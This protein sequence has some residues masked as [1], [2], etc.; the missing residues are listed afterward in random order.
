[1]SGAVAGQAAAAASIEPRPVS[2]E[3]GVAACFPMMRQLRPHLA[4]AAEFVER[5]RRQ[6]E[7]GY[8]LLALWKD[9][10]PV[11]LA[12][13]RVQENLVHGRFLYV[14]DLVTDEAERGSGFGERV[15][16]YL[17]AEAR[18]LDCRKLVLD[19]ALD[20]VRAHRFYYRNGLMAMSLRFSQAVG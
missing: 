15:M 8:R 20:N 12:G 11:S 19:T 16:D 2:D 17:K 13:Y 7:A 9:G 1:L 6:T 18:T 14:D 10:Q 5:W 4:S 3:A